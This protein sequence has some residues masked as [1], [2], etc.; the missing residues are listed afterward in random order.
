MNECIKRVLFG[1]Q[2][3]SLKQNEAIVNFVEDYLKAEHGESV[4][5]TT[6]DKVSARITESLQCFADG[7]LV[8][9]TVLTS[10]L[11]IQYTLGVE[12]WAAIS[13]QVPGKIVKD[14]NVVTG[15]VNFCYV[16]DVNLDLVLAPTALELAEK[17]R[18]VGDY[19]N[20]AESHKA[21][22]G[23]SVAW[24]LI[25]KIIAMCP[26]SERSELPADDSLAAILLSQSYWKVFE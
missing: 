14:E 15:K 20:S 7:S 3:Q 12:A 9:T 26:P 17:A 4:V 5:L 8:E 1:N 16:P 6:E 19:S 11:F 23:E 25:E 22:T 24:E 2:K 13:A 18:E 10:K 21:R